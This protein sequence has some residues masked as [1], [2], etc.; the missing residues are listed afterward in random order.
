LPP[1]PD[2]MSSVL[3]V[4]MSHPTRLGAFTILLEREA[5]PREIASELEESTQNV[6]YHLKVLVELGCIE[7]VSTKPVQGGR[8]REHFYR[9]ADRAYFDNEGWDRLNDKERLEVA[10]TLM[11][12]I[13]EDINDAMAQGTFFDPDDNHI[14]RSPMRVDDEG[15][16][17]VTAFLDGNLDGL[18][19]IQERIKERCENDEERETFPIKVD[20]I[21]FRSPEKK[22]RFK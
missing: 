6:G 10:V 21:Q 20:I 19:E 16:G 11:R 3:A 13:S 18:Y 2:L 7:L 12:V 22:I 9:A 8:V 5:S 14:S 17:E 15:W 1:T 4:A